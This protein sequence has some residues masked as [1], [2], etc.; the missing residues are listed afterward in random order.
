M[1]GAVRHENACTA[2]LDSRIYSLVSVACKFRP[3]SGGMIMS[4]FKDGRVL[5]VCFIS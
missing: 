3:G 2:G 1:V 5:C 4:C